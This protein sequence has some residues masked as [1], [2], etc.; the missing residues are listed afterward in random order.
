LGLHLSLY[1]A[2]AATGDEVLG[3]LDGLP[4]RSYQYV[5]SNLAMIWGRR[6]YS[7]ASCR[8][9]TEVRSRLYLR[10]EYL[11]GSVILTASSVLHVTLRLVV[12]RVIFHSLILRPTLFLLHQP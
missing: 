2:A 11:H 6:A 5:N 12:I 1:L 9:T 7:M 3:L 8:R 10:S 4:L